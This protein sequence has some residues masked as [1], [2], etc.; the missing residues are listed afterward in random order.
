MRDNIV[1]H[2]MRIVA[3]VLTCVVLLYTC[4]NVYTRGDTR[5]D[6]RFRRYSTRLS[7][8]YNILVS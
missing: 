8:E 5:R 7:Q 4:Y 3:R 2:A 1:S 6:L